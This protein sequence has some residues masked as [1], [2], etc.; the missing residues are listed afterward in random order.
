MSASDAIRLLW[1]N[2]LSALSQRPNQS[3]QEW[4]NT[5]SYSVDNN[6]TPEAV[7]VFPSDPKL[8]LM[9]IAH[10]LNRFSSCGRETLFGLGD[11]SFFPG[12]T[13]WPLIK[14]YYATFFYAHV[15]M[16]V[17]GVSVSFLEGTDL[18]RLRQSA[19]AYGMAEPSKIG[20]GSYLV[21]IASAPPK[22]T[23]GQVADGKG[24]HQVLWR[25]L[26]N[27]LADAESAISISSLPGSQ[28]AKAVSQLRALSVALCR[29]GSNNPNWLSTFR[30][31]INYRQAHGVWYPYKSTL[32]NN[33][34]SQRISD[35]LEG[36]ILFDAL[37]LVS[38]KPVTAFHETC[39]AVIVLARTVLADLANRAEGRRSFLAYGAPSIEEAAAARRA[40]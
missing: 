15:L 24:S 12:A 18:T 33:Y 21:T 25:A 4:L 22:L 35:V 14:L 1:P 5:A 26:N 13:G 2:G 17:T 39:L 34:L 16:R 28:K 8:A 29:Q 9:A 6:S 19:R 38:S 20:N 3:M 36:R 40:A 27:R 11:A 31:D 10:D 37:D 30:N 7:T 32:T 23:F